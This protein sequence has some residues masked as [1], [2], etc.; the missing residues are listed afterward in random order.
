[1]KKRTRLVTISSMIVILGLLVITIPTTEVGALLIGSLS[2]SLNPTNEKLF[3]I[4]NEIFET[5]FVFAK[6]EYYPKLFAL[7]MEE[8][9]KVGGYDDSILFPLRDFMLIDYIFTYFYTKEYTEFQKIFA[10]YFDDFYS[11]YSLEYFITN[12]DFFGRS[13]TEIRYIIVALEKGFLNIKGNDYISFLNSIK[14]YN[15]R[16]FILEKI[17]ATQELDKLTKEL[18]QYR[19]DY[20]NGT[21]G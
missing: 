13:E 16:I 5:R 19:E 15:M 9:I 6:R 21:R 7:P 8:S 18:E 14:N 10:E 17:G 4:C 20:Y 11:L 2:Y 3:E 1:M 12:F